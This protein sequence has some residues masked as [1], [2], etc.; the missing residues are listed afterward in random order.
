MC[1]RFGPDEAERAMKHPKH[2]RAGNRFKT[3]LND[4]L[5][6]CYLFRSRAPL[7]LHPLTPESHIE[8]NG[9]EAEPRST[10]D[11]RLSSAIQSL[12]PEV[13]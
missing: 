12:H 8:S 11:H 9:H 2:L 3:I 4:L 6:Y 10:S 5:V 1:H 7:N 13:V